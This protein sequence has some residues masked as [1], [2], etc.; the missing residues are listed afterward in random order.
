[1]SVTSAFLNVGLWNLEAVNWTHAHAHTLDIYVSTEGGGRIGI[2][3]RGELKE[4]EWE[5]G[6]ILK[7]LLDI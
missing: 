4:S 1:M 6:E 3:G 2:K 5:G 7:G